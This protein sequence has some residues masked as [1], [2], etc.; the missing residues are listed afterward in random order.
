LR[1]VA[2]LRAVAAA[3]PGLALTSS[4]RDCFEEP[5]DQD[6]EHFIYLEHGALIAAMRLSV[7]EDFSSAPIPPELRAPVPEPFVFLSQLTVHPDR[8]RQGVGKALVARV[9][10]EAE[11]LGL[12]SVVALIRVPALG[13]CFR[14]RGFT[15]A[16]AADISCGQQRAVA[17]L[18]IKT[19][20]GVV[21]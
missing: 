19:A 12:P 15:V 1:D 2:K 5:L 20:P 7:H 18:L 8:Q 4:E 13:R 9:I 6:A 14:A 16:A 11:L 10:D 17:E 21:A 3:T